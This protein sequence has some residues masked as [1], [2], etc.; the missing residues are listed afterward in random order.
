MNI[1]SDTELDTM[2]VRSAFRQERDHFGLLLA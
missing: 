2:K 1:S